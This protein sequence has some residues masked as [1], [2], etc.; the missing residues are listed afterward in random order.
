[1]FPRKRLFADMLL[2]VLLTAAPDLFI[3]DG[4]LG[5]EGNGPQSGKPIKLGVMLASDNAL[6][7]DLA[8]CEMLGIEPLVIP[9]LKRA[10]IGG[11][12]PKDIEYP[13]LSLSDVKIKRFELPSTTRK[14]T[15]L[16]PRPNDRC[17]GCGKCEEICPRGAIKVAEGKAEVAYSRCIGC[18]CCREVCPENAIDLVAVK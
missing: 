3:M 14:K 15:K 1:M 12:W 4:V 5:M 6:A 18:Y 16:R 9:T 2:D 11:I 7:I 8:V 17:V 13:L 10:G